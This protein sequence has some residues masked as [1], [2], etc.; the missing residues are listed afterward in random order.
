MKCFHGKEGE[1]WRGGLSFDVLGSDRPLHVTLLH[2]QN[3]LVNTTTH[4]SRKRFKM[5]G[6]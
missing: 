3:I 1:A 5:G 2:S 4:A 6:Q